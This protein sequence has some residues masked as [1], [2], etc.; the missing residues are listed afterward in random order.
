MDYFSS[1]NWNFLLPSHLL[2]LL[3][4]PAM[5]Q[6]LPPLPFWLGTS[7][8]IPL[9][10]CP[11]LLYFSEHNA[12]DD[13]IIKLFYSQN[14]SKNSKIHETKCYWIE[15][16]K[17]K[18]VVNISKFCNNLDSCQK[19]ENS[20]HNDRYTLITSELNSIIK[21][22]NAENH[23]IY[24]L[25]DQEVY[26]EF[27][28]Y[29]L[30]IYY[31]TATSNADNDSH[32]LIK[33]VN[34]LLG[35][36]FCDEYISVLALNLPHLC[37]DIVNHLLLL[38]RQEQAKVSSSAS[39]IAVVDAKSGLTY[40]YQCSTN[41]I[42]NIINRIASKHPQIAE[43][44]R[45]LLVSNQEFP[46]LILDISQQYLVHTIESFIDENVLFCSSNSNDNSDGTSWLIMADNTKRIEDISRHSVSNIKK[47]LSN[48]QPSPTIT[49]NGNLMAQELI[50]S[51]RILTFLQSLLNS[52]NYVLYLQQYSNNQY[53]LHDIILSYLVSLRNSND[54]QLRS[55]IINLRV[56]ISFIFMKIILCWRLL[57]SKSADN[58]LDLVSI[59]SD[60]YQVL[61]IDAYQHLVSTSPVDN[62]VKSYAIYLEI[63][64]KYSNNLALRELL[65]DE[66]G[67]RHS[68]C[69][70]LLSTSTTSFIPNKI[71]MQILN[72]MNLVYKGDLS[73]KNYVTS[74]L[75]VKDNDYNQIYIPSII[76]RLD[77][78]PGDWTCSLT[79]LFVHDLFGKCGVSGEIIHNVMTNVMG[80][81]HY[82]PHTWSIKLVDAWLSRSIQPVPKSNLAVKS[83]STLYESSRV[84]ITGL[85]LL[86]SE[87]KVLTRSLC[88]T[89][90]EM[91]STVYCNIC[92]NC[93]G[94]DCDISFFSPNQ[95]SA[96]NLIKSSFLVT[97]ACN[98][99]DINLQ[100]WRSGWSGVLATY[101]ALK[102]HAI[103][104]DSAPSNATLF[105]SDY[106]ELPIIRCINYLTNTIG[107]HIVQQFV[108][109]YMSLIRRFCP[110]ILNIDGTVVSYRYQKQNL[111]LSS[112][113]Q[114]SYE[115]LAK[116]DSEHLDKLASDTIVAY[117]CAQLTRTSTNKNKTS[118][119]DKVVD[120]CI[121]TL[122]SMREKCVKTNQSSDYYLMLYQIWWDVYII[123]PLPQMIE[124]NTFNKILEFFVHRQSSN[125]SYPKY[126]PNYS[127]L[128]EEPMVLFR[129]PYATIINPCI[130]R[131]VNRIVVSALLASKV[132]IHESIQYKLKLMNRYNHGTDV[133]TVVPRHNL[134]IINTINTTNYY[135]L[136]LLI[137]IRLYI[138]LW[139]EY[140]SMD[141]VDNGCSDYSDLKNVIHNTIERILSL[142]IISAD[143]AGLGANNL[144]ALLLH[145]QL[146]T[147]GFELLSSN[148]TIKGPLLCTILKIVHS[149][150]N[151][152]ASNSA[153][154]V[155][156]SIDINGF[157]SILKHIHS[158]LTIHSHDDVCRSIVIA[159]PSFLYRGTLSINKYI[160]R[161]SLLLIETYTGLIVD[162]CIKYY[163]YVVPEFIKM[164]NE[165][166]QKGKEEDKKC[167]QKLREII[168]S[169][170]ESIGPSDA[171]TGSKSLVSCVIKSH[172]DL[173]F[174]SKQNKVV[175]ASHKRKRTDK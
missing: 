142:N 16:S 161:S 137:A 172:I 35:S 102:Y 100:S 69:A 125:Y 43:N 168:R 121:Q 28:K 61:L 175:A 80:K 171:S 83:N 108:P 128:V 33:L 114:L 10:S 110:E 156:A 117:V 97:C 112:Q 76:S 14:C 116:Y 65:L 93:A 152:P 173:F 164:I 162:L 26:A 5:S 54:C 174:P 25:L 50:R 57:N 29:M 153:E 109:G 89:H 138:E 66:L 1:G 94:S 47:Y 63:A 49:N 150:F 23:P 98:F 141:K 139:T 78:S 101:Y 135:Q 71:V 86:P 157:E 115:I 27:I 132:S 165:T 130:L 160:P 147:V 62:N 129:L 74:L 13:G 91:K 73:D 37:R 46:S 106:R 55:T 143:S 4:S 12:I 155:V 123:H 42:Y 151:T 21:N 34:I 146:T 118:N 127:V 92:S 104:M 136:Q 18:V 163:S 52:K 145:H 111:T 56:I 75:H 88:L 134:S 77:E 72:Q 48:T 24:Y 144:F 53:D 103:N 133:A 107:N 113:T 3:W 51:F 87:V 7:E 15:S 30:P 41:Y 32:L 45:S 59:E 44:I 99:R 6:L 119:G 105:L 19:F 96:T 85:P 39:T 149:S 68:R 17:K 170:L 9:E 158:V 2:P 95:I 79:L 124:L 58:N 126:I 38:I 36:S 64:L 122:D 67:L 81:L 154:A 90:F 166:T 8:L 60:K 120:I 148:V 11:I 82:P 131:I 159:L 169:R 140:I 31:L 167:M 20:S 84:S 40:N 22:N 70:S